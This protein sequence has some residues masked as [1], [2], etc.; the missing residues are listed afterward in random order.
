VTVNNSKHAQ[1][2]IGFNQEERPKGDFYPSPP[3]AVQSL[4]DNEKFGRFVWEPACGNGVVSEVLKT[5]G[6]KVFSSD[7]YDWGYGEQRDFNFLNDT[8][9]IFPHA[10][11]T[12]PPFNIPKNASHDFAV[13]ALEYT[14]GQDGKVAFLQRLQW[15]EGKKRQ[16]LF[17]K[18]PFKKLLVFSGRIP[19]MHR[20]DFEGVPSSSMMAFGWFIWDWKHEGPPTIEWI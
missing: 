7:V 18:Y 17:T 12:N 13:K 2:L 1:Q 5:N 4:L 14:K 8:M 15:L 11:I 16:H 19:R 10:I 20:F 3:S 6:Y 9:S